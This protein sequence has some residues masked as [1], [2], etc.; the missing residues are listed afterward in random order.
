MR[1]MKTDCE[2]GALLIAIAVSNR[3]VAFR[4]IYFIRQ[5]IRPSLESQRGWTPNI[6]LQSMVYKRLH[7]SEFKVRD[8]CPKSSFRLLTAPAMKSIRSSPS[9]MDRLSSPNVATW[10]VSKQIQQHFYLTAFTE[11]ISTTFVWIS[12]S[13]I[14]RFRSAHSTNVDQQATCMVVQ[15][16]VWRTPLGGVHNTCV[17]NSVTR[18]KVPGVYC[19][20]HAGNA[21]C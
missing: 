1:K 15:L 9:L 17:K 7:C 14:S 8:V 3:Q 19:N 5:V 6:L 2:P 21:T 11:K 20:R 10:I 18:F 12:D 13:G 16:W 4:R